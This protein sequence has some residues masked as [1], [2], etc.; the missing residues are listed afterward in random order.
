MSYVKIEC[1][2]C[3]K[4]YTINISEFEFESVDTDERQ[5][6]A[7]ITPEGNVEIS[8]DCGN[9]IEITHHFW[10]YPE[11]FEN[12][13]ETDISGAEIIQDEL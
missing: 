2:N 10:E 6:G 12:H 8:C 5:V 3:G 4:S 13:S 9:T 1:D 7:E 11:G